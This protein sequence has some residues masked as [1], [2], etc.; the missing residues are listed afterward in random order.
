MVY[1]VQT[2]PDSLIMFAACHA[3]LT[4]QPKPNIVDNNNWIEWTLNGKRWLNKIIWILRR[5]R[6]Q[7][8]EVTVFKIWN[9]YGRNVSLSH[10]NILFGFFFFIQRKGKFFWN[11]EVCS[12]C[13]LS[14]ASYQLPVNSVLIWIIFFMF[15]CA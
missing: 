12:G 1:D 9:K 5:G 6:K 10:S 3:L 8:E 7:F 15:R 13:Q 4:K 11:M 2:Y 14:I